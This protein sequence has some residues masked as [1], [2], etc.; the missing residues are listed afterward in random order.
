M[1]KTYFPNVKIVVYRYHFIRQVYCSLENVRKNV[2]KSLM[3]QSHHL[4]IITNTS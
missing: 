4:E 2:Q 1:A 3:R